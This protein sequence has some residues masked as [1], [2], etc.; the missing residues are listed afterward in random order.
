MEISYYHHADPN[1]YDDQYVLYRQSVS[2][3]DSN[4]W[5]FLKAPSS[6]HLNSTTPMPASSN[7]PLQPRTTPSQTAYLQ[8][9]KIR[10]GGCGPNEKCTEEPSMCFH[11]VCHAT[12]PKP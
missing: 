3:L 2:E 9:C 4:N 12:S 8:Q 11:P 7:K 6:W 5:N 10:N 1:D